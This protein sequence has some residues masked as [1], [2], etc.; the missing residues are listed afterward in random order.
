VRP[1]LITVQTFARERRVQL[2]YEE[3]PRNLVNS[4]LAAEDR[5]FFS[6]GV[7]ADPSPEEGLLVE[8]PEDE[9]E[10][11]RFWLSTLPAD[12]DPAELVRLTKLR[13]RIERDHLDLKQE[14]GLG[15]YEGRGWRGFHPHISLCIAAYGFLISEAETIPPSAPQ[16]ARFRQKTPL[17]PGGRPRGS[18]I[19][20]AASF[21]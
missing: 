16:H 13:W 6:H 12:I 1:E 17:P 11:T 4:F 19:A 9:A 15:H 2:S 18:P 14:C 3:F 8:W 7:R 10:P 20:A 5:T 21:A